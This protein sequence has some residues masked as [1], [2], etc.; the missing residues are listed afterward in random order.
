VTIGVDELVERRMPATI[1]VAPAMLGRPSF[2]WD[3]LASSSGDGLP[4][5]VRNESL[6]THRGIDADVREWAGGEGMG[7]WPV[8]HWARPATEE[9]LAVAAGRPGISVASHSWSH[10]NLT[11]LTPGRLEEELEKPLGWL[12]DRFDCVR[13]W[14]AYP[15]GLSSG[16]VEAAAGRLGYT[17]GVRVEGGWIRKQRDRRLSLPRLNIPAG[18]SQAGFELRSAGFFCR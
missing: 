15:Y 8:S 1:F 9:E 7:V 2:W 16:E 4:D 5:D 18:V 10:P 11:R 13:P 14:L 3:A 17:I 6:T 12:R